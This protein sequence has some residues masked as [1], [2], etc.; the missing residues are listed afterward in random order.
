VQTPRG[1]KADEED[2]EDEEA[3]GAPR[4]RVDH[5]RPRIAWTR[6][7]SSWGLKGFFT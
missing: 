2:A 4:E 7:P 1:E 6:A 5:L 3:H